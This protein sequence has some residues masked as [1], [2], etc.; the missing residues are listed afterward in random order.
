MQ[1]GP[2]AL[3]LALTLAL[4]LAL[5]RSART[6]GA[7]PIGLS[8]A[9]RQLHRSVCAVASPALFGGASWANVKANVKAKSRARA[10]IA[11]ST[12][13]SIVDVH[14]LDDRPPLRDLRWP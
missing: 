9:A 11:S 8:N 13:Y 1:S 14:G 5:M 3:D 6:R 4:T 2:R 10:R 12:F 7:Q